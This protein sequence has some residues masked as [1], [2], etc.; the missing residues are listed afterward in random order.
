MDDS[1]PLY[2]WPNDG[3]LEQLLNNAAFMTPY[4]LDKMNRNVS[5]I[6]SEERLKASPPQLEND[7]P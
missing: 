5:Q 6:Y 3:S 1:S 7:A 4:G 2:R